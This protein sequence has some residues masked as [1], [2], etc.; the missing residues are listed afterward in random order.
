MDRLLLREFKGRVPRI[1]PKLLPET[2]AQIATNCDLRS[3]NI[4]GFKALDQGA[5][6]TA[7]SISANPI[8]TELFT[9]TLDC[10]FV[11]HTVSDVPVLVVSDGTA[12]PKQYTDALYPADHRRLGVVPPSTALTV[13]FGTIP[14][15]DTDEI[16]HTISY[17]YTY[18]TSWGE[19]S[20]PSP[21]SAVVE[22]LDNQYVTLTNFDNPTVA[23]K[24]D[25]TGMRIYRL[26]TGTLGA[27]YQ[28]LAE[29]DDLATTYDDYDV[30][31]KDLN[32]VTADTLDT[33]GW[34]Q[35]PDTLSGLIRYANGM[36]AG[37][38]GNAL[39]LS[40]PFII[41][42][43]PLKYVLTFDSDIVGIAAYNQAI[44]VITETKPYIVTGHSPANMVVDPVTVQQGCVAK[45]GVVETNLGVI[46]PSPDGLMLIDGASGTNITKD[47]ITKEQWAALSISDLISFWYDDMYI[48]FF[49]GTDTGFTIIDGTW[50][51]L[52][53]N[54]GT[55]EGGY[56][57]A[58]DDKLYLIIDRTTFYIET[59]NDHATTYLDWEWKSK[60]FTFSY[61]TNFSCGRVDSASFAV[62]GSINLSF[63]A[64]GN[65]IATSVTMTADIFRLPAL[66]RY[67]DFEVRAQGQSDEDL[68]SMIFAVSPALLR[69][70]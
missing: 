58:E 63:Y 48:G 1:A 59:F 22:V 11:R 50:I 25:V 14:G 28:F 45:R 4:K 44:I 15:V 53:L 6:I 34:I 62:A 68:E 13:A 51:D 2:H 37:F 55:V 67:W 70:V 10:D 27:E 33:E 36:Y 52:D 8:D 54:G 12:Y 56:V 41:Y 30:S 66:S 18:V 64:D 7:S 43:W 32:A 65:L 31:E 9:S 38:D 69:F 46:Y 40:E 5:S 47:L 35:P 26:A 23:D 20:A 24:N 21:A 17:V 61:P 49:A 16:N 39:Y 3:G 57:S 19:E 42:A 29:V 60:L